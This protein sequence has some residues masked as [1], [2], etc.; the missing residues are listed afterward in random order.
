MEPHR[1]LVFTASEEEEEGGFPL[2]VSTLYCHDESPC[3]RTSQRRSS[4]DTVT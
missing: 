4:D 2:P 1:G 3:H